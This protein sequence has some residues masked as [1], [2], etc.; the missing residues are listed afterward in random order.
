MMLMDFDMSS[1]SWFL[2]TSYSNLYRIIIYVPIRAGRPRFLSGAPWCDFAKPPPFGDIKKGGSSTDFKQNAE[3][4]N[5]KNVPQVWTINKNI[6]KCNVWY[7]QRSN[8]LHPSIYETRILAVSQ[9]TAH[10]HRG[11][12]LR[13]LFLV[14]AGTSSHC[15]VMT[16]RME[17]RFKRWKTYKNI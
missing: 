3:A 6:W 8:C 2:P 17:L 1:S 9:M 7:M 10:L 13:L 12:C 4:T 15:V 11:P 16:S 14:Q 5:E